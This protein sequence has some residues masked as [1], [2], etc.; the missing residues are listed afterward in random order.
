M[1]TIIETKDLVYAYPR[2]ENEPLRYALN[3]VDISIEKGSFVVVLGHNGF[4][5]VEDE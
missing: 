5:I 3:G 4:C 1:S 2:E